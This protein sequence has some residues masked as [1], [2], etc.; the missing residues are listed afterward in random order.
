MTYY[1]ARPTFSTFALILITLLA[2]SSASWAQ[3][4]EGHKHEAGGT[5]KEIPVEELNKAGALPEI[6]IGKPN[7]QITIIEYA[8]MTCGHCGRFHRD[9]LPQ[10]KAKYI[11][12]GAARLL[13]REFPLG[14]V[15]L[16]ASMLPRCVSSDKS[17]DFIETL[18]AR[19]QLWLQK[20]NIRPRLV[21]IS[22]EF[23]MTESTLDSCLQDDSLVEK[24]MSSRQ[25][26]VE[27]FG[28]KSTPT[29]FINGK[30]LVGPQS[31][32]EFD[33]II[34]PMLK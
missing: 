4:H 10:V 34:Q 33:K 24:V 19:Q 7:A 25:R 20:G 12:T 31:I 5:L 26:A 29:F 18:F 30:P 16:A 32:V 23:G 3:G 17:Y 22:K 11:D 1:N 9:L 15:A 13:V 2:T 6:S 14:K 21:R 8:S 27:E 28:V